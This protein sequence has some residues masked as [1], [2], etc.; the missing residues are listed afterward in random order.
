MHLNT[1]IELSCGG[2]C[3]LLLRIRKQH[4][5]KLPIQTSR[6]IWSTPQLHHI[7]IHCTVHHQAGFTA[8]WGGRSIKEGLLSS[9]KPKKLTLASLDPSSYFKT[10]ALPLPSIIMPSSEGKP[11]GSPRETPTVPGST[12]SSKGVEGEQSEKKIKKT[13]EEKYLE[14]LYEQL[15]HF[16]YRKYDPQTE[17]DHKCIP[18]PATGNT[19]GQTFMC[20]VN[21]HKV[22]EKPKRPIYQYDVS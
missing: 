22:L 21:M 15:R 20:P 7:F 2:D 11:S 12:T 19:T 6:L 5:H 9:T 13:K 17:V 1:F 3:Q 18:R 8:M 10:L 4:I 14:H 16:T